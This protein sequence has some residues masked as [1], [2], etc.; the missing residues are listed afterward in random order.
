MTDNVPT[1]LLMPTRVYLAIQRGRGKRL[2]PVRKR[3][4]RLVKKVAKRGCWDTTFGTARAKR[5]AKYSW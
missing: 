3:P 2:M 4:K 1:V 5:R